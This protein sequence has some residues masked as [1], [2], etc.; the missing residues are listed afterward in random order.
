MGRSKVHIFFP[1]LWERRETCFALQI[2]FL[3]WFPFYFLMWLV[4]R[5]VG[6]REFWKE[7]RRALG[8]GGVSQLFLPWCAFLEFILSPPAF[9]EAGPWGQSLSVHL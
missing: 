1:L 8:K 5:K 7:L 3:I 6:L 2:V 9:G 4:Q